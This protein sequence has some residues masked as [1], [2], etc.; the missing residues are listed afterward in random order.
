[1]IP[2]VDLPAVVDVVS[3]PTDMDV[4]GPQADPPQVD[5]LL[6]MLSLIQHWMLVSK[7]MH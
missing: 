7:H 2:G 6:M 1:M 4:G 3:K 5:A